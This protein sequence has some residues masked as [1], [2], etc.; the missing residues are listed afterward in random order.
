MKKII[1]ALT[2]ALFA[3]ITLKAQNSMQ[4]S[5]VLLV[6]ALDTV[7]QG[8]VWKVTNVLQSLVGNGSFK[9]KVNGND[10]VVGYSL[11]S[12]GQT[13]GTG[14]FQNSHNY[15]NGLQGSY[16]LP[17]YT[18]LQVGENVKYISVIEFNIE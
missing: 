2:L 13:N 8:K 18:T 12:N 6:E 4:F 1:L 16:W 3:N 5:K 11:S 14:N 7:P 17:E 15:Y 9:I 10:I